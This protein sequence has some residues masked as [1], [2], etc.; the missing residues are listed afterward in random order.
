MFT[1]RPLADEHPSID[2]DERG[3]RDEQNFG[4]R[5]VMSGSRR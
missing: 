3:R 5:G 4:H 2:I 1:M